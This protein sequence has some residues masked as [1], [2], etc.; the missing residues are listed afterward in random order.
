MWCRKCMKS[1]SLCPVSFGL[2]LGLTCAIAIMIWGVWMMNYGMPAETA[3]H[4]LTPKSF[5]QV[6]LM[7]GWG[8]LKGFIFGGVFALIYDGIVCFC[9]SRCC[10]SD[11][12]QVCDCGPSCACVKKNDKSNTVI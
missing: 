5:G 6:S 4:M 9:K 11:G 3:G 7:A 8:L 1:K 12:E 2:A 10:K